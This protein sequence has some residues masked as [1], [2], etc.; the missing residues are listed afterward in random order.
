MN[1]RVDVRDALSTVR[2]PA[3]VLHRRDDRDSR[4]EEGRY[5]AE[6]IS[7][8]RFVELAGG[9][10]FVAADPDQI[11]DEIEPFVAERARSEA[12]GASTPVTTALAAVLACEPGDVEAFDG[13][14]TAVR[15]ALERLVLTP[16]LRAGVDI[17][18]VARR[19]AAVVGGNDHLAGLLAA[20]ARSGDILTTAAV[21]DLASGSGLEF[22]P[23]GELD[24]GAAGRRAVF[25][26]IR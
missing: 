10:H 20:Q 15:A 11:L 26:V 16:G 1:S 22:R 7:G 8:A 2:V 17:A 24:L 14:A 6:R 9:D 23:A 3:L 25:R 21:A 13:P 4:P 19:G 12:T 18:E 5:I